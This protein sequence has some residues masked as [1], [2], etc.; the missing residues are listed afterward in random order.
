MT[1]GIRKPFNPD[2]SL[3]AIQGRNSPFVPRNEKESPQTNKS[4]A[5]TPPSMTEVIAAQESKT[6]KK[7]KKIPEQVSS[8]SGV[9]NQTGYTTPTPTGDVGTDHHGGAGVALNED[10]TV[11][12]TPTTPA[13]EIPLPQ[14]E[15][16][17]VPEAPPSGA[18]ESSPNCDRSLEEN[19]S[20]STSSH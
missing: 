1:Q 14:R 11:K 10:G 17:K 9:S 6:P 12:I 16:K 2:H 4:K 19:F 8:N 20:S 3:E 7:A 5:Q 13:V 15:R 18:T